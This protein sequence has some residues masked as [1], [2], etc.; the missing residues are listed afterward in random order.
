MKVIRNEY[1]MI[2]KG[3]RTLWYKEKDPTKKDLVEDFANRLKKEWNNN[4]VKVET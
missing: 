1:E 2:L 3:L 4:R